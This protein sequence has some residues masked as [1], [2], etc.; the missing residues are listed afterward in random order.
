MFQKKKKINVSNNNNN[1]ERSINKNLNELLD[2]ADD[3][4]IPFIDNQNIKASKTGMIEKNIIK[5]KGIISDKMKEE[6]ENV[7]NED[8]RENE[9]IKNK[10]LKK[11]KRK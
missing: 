10:R 11:K 6:N 7:T 5:K 2:K 9:K 8:K 4:D 3:E 1:Y